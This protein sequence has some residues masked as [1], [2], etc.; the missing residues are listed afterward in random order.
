MS[1]HAKIHAK[2]RTL[3]ESE[4]RIIRLARLDPASKIDPRNRRDAHH[5]IYSTVLLLRDEN[6]TF[7]LDWSWVHGQDSRK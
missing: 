7:I 6:L 3:P 1:K 2:S 5:L 4:L